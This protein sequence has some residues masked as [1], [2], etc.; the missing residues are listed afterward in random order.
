ME[1]FKDFV[2]RHLFV[3]GMVCGVVACVWIYGTFI[4]EGYEQVKAGYESLAPLG[5]ACTPE[6][7]ADAVLWLVDGARTVTGELLLLDG[8]LHLGPAQGV[9]VP[10]K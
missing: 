2:K 4:K 3:E 6:D 10:G 9:R 5:H 7:V 8:G 1:K